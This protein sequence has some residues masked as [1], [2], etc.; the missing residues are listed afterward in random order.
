MPVP[1]S[2]KGRIFALLGYELVE[3]VIDDGKIRERR[4]VSYAPGPLAVAR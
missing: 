3:G 1:S 2:S 4:R